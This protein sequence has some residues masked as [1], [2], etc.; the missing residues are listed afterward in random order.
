MHRGMRRGMQR[1][2]GRNAE[3][4]REECRKEWDERNCMQWNA[5]RNAEKN[6]EECRRTQRSVE[7]NAKRN[8]E[9]TVWYGMKEDGNM[10]F[11]G[12]RGWVGTRDFLEHAD[13]NMQFFGTRICVPVGEAHCTRS[14]ARVQLPACDRKVARFTALFRAGGL[15]SSWVVGG[16]CTAGASFC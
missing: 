15:A 5:E 6:A 2:A 1:N 3:E 14:C 7:R 13:G 9:E 10:Q 16:S 4:C 12:T 11:F 8:A